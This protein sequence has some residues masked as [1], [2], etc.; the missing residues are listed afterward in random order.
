MKRLFKFVSVIILTCM[1]ACVF[2]SCDSVDS[3]PEESKQASTT[4]TADET[5]SV[6]E[7]ETEN[8][9]SISKAIGISLDY[10]SGKGKCTIYWGERKGARTGRS[11]LGATRF[12][13]R[14]RKSK[15]YHEISLSGSGGGAGI[16]IGENNELLHLIVVF[17]KGYKLTENDKNVINETGIDYM[18][19]N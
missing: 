14:T 18:F 2:V 19:E 15:A 17:K 1:I 10:Y 3:M 16:E 8:P 13:Y 5:E 11:L 6:T 9:Y 7:E 12:L 4:S